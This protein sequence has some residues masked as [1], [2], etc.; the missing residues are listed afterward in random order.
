MS[1]TP[2]EITAGIEALKRRQALESFK[3]TRAFQDAKARAEFQAVLLVGPAEP[4]PQAPGTNHPPM[5]DLK[6]V[7]SA[8][9]ET[10]LRNHQSHHHRK[11]VIFGEVWVA[12]LKHAARLEKALTTMLYGRD[13]SERELGAWVSIY[14][15][16]PR[17][18]WP[19]LL[20]AAVTEVNERE[21]LETY[22]AE[23]KD[24]EI[25]KTATTG[26]PTLRRVK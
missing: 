12:T 19:E 1:T 23:E 10:Y 18:L 21:Y 14:C 24:S 8:N 15:D 26:R 16:S 6:V 4:T 11:R 9:P 5:W 2:D 13:G 25:A 17:Q 20:L 22:T 7:T 3:K